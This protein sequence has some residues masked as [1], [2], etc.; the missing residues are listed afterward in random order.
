MKRRVVSIWFQRLPSERVLRARPVDGPFAV[1]LSEGNHDRLHDLNR[2]AEGQGLERGMGLADARAYVPDLVTRPADIDADRRFLVM[3]ARWATRYTPHAGL[4]GEDGLVLD[5]TGASHLFGGEAAMLEDMKERLARARLSAR[6]GIADTRGAAWAL[7]HFAPGI[8][9]E[10][11][12]SAAL[13]PLSVSALRIDEKTATA[14]K[15][16][17]LNTI[18]D[19]TALPRATL[20]RRFDMGLIEKLEQALGTRGE[21]VSPLSGPPHYGVRMSFPEPIGLVD[22]V[23]AA[24]ARLLDTLCLRLKNR[25]AGARAIML[26]VERVDQTRQ[27]VTLRLARPMRDAPRILRLFERPVGEIDAGFGIERIRLEAR[28]V[29][30]LP[31]EQIGEGGL[32]E[33]EA[34]DDLVTRLGARIGLDNIVR[35]QPVASHIPERGFTENPAAYGRVDAEWRMDQPRPLRMF[36]P[37]PVTSDAA[38]R[39]P[40]RFSWRRMRFETAASSGP[41]RIAPE[42]WRPDEAWRS[43][44]RDYWRVDTRQGL[45]LWMFHTPQAP[46][47]FV[48]GLFA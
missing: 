33:G 3:L 30:G 7:A 25:E 43:G 45:R 31:A 35:F 12:T 29:E 20:A 26:S 41:E 19:M 46:G 2:E 17:G 28:G 15:R 32:V 5:I 16:L 6:I 13:G 1:T 36:P 8:A 23:M 14:L 10:G 18:A 11:K 48:H 9:P 47:W 4:D 24:L 42:W 22:D 34:L 37:E 40:S 21:A 38:R 44:L 27:T 39:P